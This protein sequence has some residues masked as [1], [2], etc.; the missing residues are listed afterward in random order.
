[1]E[2]FF[3][4]FRARVEAETPDL[5]A[6]LREAAPA[7]VPHGYG[8]LP[9]L[10]P[11]PPLTSRP[12]RIT[13]TSFSW[14]RTESFIDQ[15][16]RRLEKLETRLG[17]AAQLGGEERRREWAKMVDEYRPLAG[18]LRLIANHIEYNRLWQAEIARNRRSYDVNTSLHDAVLE[19]QAILDTLQAGDPVLE[20]SLRAREEALWARIH[21]VTH[22]VSPPDF[23]RVEHPSPHRWIIKVPLHT[24]IEDQSFV[25]AF[26]AAVE[27][28]WH[29]RDGEDEFSVALEIRGVPASQLYPEGSVPAHGEHLDQSRHIARFPAG[30]AV[31]TTGSNS[32]YVL[33]L[34]I[35]IGPH[36]IGP[37]ALAHEVGHILGFPDGYFRGYRDRGPE[38]F[39]VLEVM[40]DVDDIMSQPGNGRV[41]RDHFKR[42]LEAR[43]Y[44][45]RQAAPGSRPSHR[46]GRRS[47]SPAPPR[48]RC[49]GARARH[50]DCPS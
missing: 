37:T 36:D 1:M 41:Q 8:I 18:N 38:G 2:Q 30:G 31:L 28:A 23:L 13:S 10:V 19:R 49:H 47:R 15:D 42:L 4:T 17:E 43:G 44:P 7:S 35:D 9:R 20:L 12:S 3:E 22:K 50:I 14:R 27:Q 29:V 11:D 34:S 25:D 5:L 21:D 6:K 39:E 24:D 26:R 32:T 16:V 33:G 40:T 46:A 48:R 45:C